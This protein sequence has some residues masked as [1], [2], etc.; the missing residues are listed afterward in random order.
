VIRWG[1]A[2]PGSIANA[3]A[4]TMQVVDGGEIGAVASRSVERAAAFAEEFAIPRHYGD[5]GALAHDDGVDVVY[6]AT[7]HA[8]HA[9][10]TLAYLSGGKHVLCEK[11]LALNAGQVRA[12]TDAARAQG[13]FLM[14]ALWSRFLPS[15]RL[16]TEV[17]AAGRIGQPLFAEAD[18]GFRAPIDPNGRLFDLAQGGGALL[19]L[20]IYALHLC[21]LVLGP[22]ERAVAAGVVGETG[23][24]EV[25]AAIL[26]H[27]GGT[28][29]VIKAAI[30]ANLSSTGRIAGTEGSIEIPPYMHCPQSIT[31]VAPGGGREVLQA[32]FELRQGFRYEIE[33]VH[34]CLA[35]GATESAVM[36]LA[37]SLALAVV[38]DDIRSQ[39]GVVYPGE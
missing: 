24:D 31:V 12:M 6:V 19:D 38:M 2:G 32:P 13:R 25:T 20:G 21:T 29:G 8:R 36:P 11:P 5:Y 27:R 23:V 7:P 37:E 9:A 33:E 14:E 16:L 34:R 39:L 1:I 28:I 30:R 4:T 17:L 35:D 22:V 15:Y 18:F 26:H 3:F 10:D